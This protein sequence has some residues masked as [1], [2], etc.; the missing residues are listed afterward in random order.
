MQNVECNFGC[1]AR[2][3]ALL[4]SNVA[5][6]LLLKFCEQ[7]FVQH[8]S[9]TIT[10]DCNGL[11]LL[12]FEKNG[13]IMP[14]DQNPHQTETCFGRVSFLMYTYVFS[15]IARILFVYIPAKIKMSFI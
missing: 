4:Q 5:N 9:I 11:S 10:I 1:V 13:T 14:M 12:I 6:S 2:N 7:K 15:E 8:G 3:A